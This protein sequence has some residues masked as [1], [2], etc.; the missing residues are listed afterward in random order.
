MPYRRTITAANAAFLLVL[1]VAVTDQL[2]ATA[3]QSIYRPRPGGLRFNCSTPMTRL[4]GKAVTI[5]P[6]NIC[7]DLGMGNANV[8]TCTGISALQLQP[9]DNEEVPL[10]RQ[11]E[12]ES[13]IRLIN[14]HVCIMHMLCVLCAALDIL[15]DLTRQVSGE[16]R[17][18][19]QAPIKSVSAT[20]KHVP[21]AV[22][23][24]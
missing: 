13:S 20:G 4:L 3:A 21:G 18:H 1:A 7:K 16:C 23:M 14:C 10:T 24:Q 22:Q 2:A 17:P 9:Y 5:G 12:S 8:L 19:K 15:N 6:E 11:H